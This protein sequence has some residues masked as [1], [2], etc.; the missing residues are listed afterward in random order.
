LGYLNLQAQELAKEHLQKAFLKSVKS[1]FK[2]GMFKRRE[3]TSKRLFMPFEVPR[4]TKRE[5]IVPGTGRR[6]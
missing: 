5:L 2:R 4:L 6:D 1:G 3:K